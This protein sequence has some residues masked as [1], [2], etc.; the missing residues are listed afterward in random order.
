MSSCVRLLALALSCVCVL[1]SCN[2]DESDDIIIWD[3][4]PVEFNIE[5]VNALGEDLVNPAHPHSLAKQPITIEMDGTTYKLR[6]YDEASEEIRK[7]SAAQSSH[8]RYYL[9]VLYGFTYRKPYEVNGPWILSF[10][11]FAGEKNADRSI[12]LHWPNGKT[13]VLRYTNSFGWEGRGDNLRPKIER[14]F[15][16]NGKRVDEPNAGGHIYR[17]IR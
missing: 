11:E 12:K 7:R 17:F 3:I 1:A 13:D 16:L 5:V 4:A 2:K 9:A 8:S 6:S 15:Y 10:G 14:H